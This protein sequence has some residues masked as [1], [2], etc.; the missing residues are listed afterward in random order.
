MKKPQLKTEEKATF[1]AYPES[2]KQAD[3][4]KYPSNQYFSYNSAQ[5]LRPYQLPKQSD[6]PSKN[7][8]ANRNSR[9]PEFIKNFN[10]TNEE[11]RRQ[12]PVQ[13]PTNSRE[14]AY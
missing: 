14:E 10:R 11:K 12:I 6:S 9:K 8:S 2:R 13:F 3:A 7:Q 1:S 4:Y 5:N